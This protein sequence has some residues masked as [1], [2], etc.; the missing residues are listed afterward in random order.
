MLDA[1]PLLRY[2]ALKLMASHFH[3][4]ALIAFAAIFHYRRR[5]FIADI[6]YTRRYAMPISAPLIFFRTLITR[7]HYKR[8][9]IQLFAM[10]PYAYAT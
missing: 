2:A 6:D 8:N 5:V 9:C 7:R 10:P 1:M 4:V 3:V